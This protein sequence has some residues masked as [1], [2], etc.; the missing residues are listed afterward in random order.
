MTE[1]KNTCGVV[2]PI[3]LC[4]GLDAKHWTDVL[5]IVEAA[6]T[7]AGFEARLVSDTFESNLI[8]KEILQNIYKDELIVCDVSGKNPNV[9]FELGV[10]MA[11]QK[12]TV[13]I[14]DN[15]TAYPFDTGPNRYIEYPRD[16]RHPEMEK[17]K[18]NLSAS[19]TKT[20]AQ[21]AENSFI[22]QLGPFQIPDV[23]SSTV[24]ASEIILDRLDRL[25]KRLVQ[26]SDFNHRNG[27]SAVR[28]NLD[29]SITFARVDAKTVLAVLHD[30]NVDQIKNGLESFVNAT[31]GKI[32]AK[33]QTLGSNQAVIRLVGERVHEVK[34]QTLF[35]DFIDDAIPF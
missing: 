13:I 7:H 34:I 15:K 20:F 6:A 19:M 22:G 27:I 4:D 33:I 3:S 18:A 17:F 12:P 28:A 8:H 25:E 30:Y 29:S 5:S 32:E 21:S 11:T 9:F 2:M 1:K 35:I 14:K 10:R 31:D 23:E 24:P 26:N 16:L